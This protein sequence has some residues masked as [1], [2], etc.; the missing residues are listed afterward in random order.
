MEFF[1]SMSET[2]KYNDDDHKTLFLKTLNEQRLEGEFC[3]I[4]I[5]VE[6][7]KFRA[8]RC[9]LAACSTYFKKLFK[10]L[11]VDSSSVIEIDFLRSDIFEEVLNYMYTAK[12][13]VKKEDVNLM[14][15]SGQIL[16]IRFLDKLCSQ[17]RDVSS[18]D[19]S[20]GQSKSKYCLKLNRPI[21]D[22]ADAQDDD[23]EEI[24]DQ[25]DSP[26]DDTVEG[27]PPSQEDGKSPTTTL[28]VQEAILKELGSEEVRKV[29]C[30][31]QE[32]E[33]METPESKDL[34]SQTPQALTFNDGM[35]EVKDEQTP[36]W[37]T[38]AS[39]MKFE[40]LLYGHH[41]EQIACQACGK[42]FSDEGRL[43]KHEKLHTAD[44]PFVCEMCTK[45]FTT[46]A[47]LKEHLKIHTGYKPYSCEVCG[48]SFIRAPDLK[49][50]ERVHSNERPF[51]CHMCDKAFKHKSHLKDHERRHR[52]EKPF[53]CGSC[54][55]AFAKASDL[56]RHENNMHNERKQVTPSAIQ[57]ETEQL[58]AAAMAA[59][60]EQQLETIACS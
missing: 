58:Q 39:D 43:R 29:N 36:G 40:Y 10:K 20:N 16:G 55:K 41:R 14:M 42:T 18:P 23:V 21:G 25:D 3:D 19:E 47:H 48:K 24:G 49:K 46:Q 60:A 57:S 8:H 32:V 15:S 1:I 52:G 59:E 27:T 11:E 30:Y 35:G 37:T 28:R 9:V 5:V 44:R 6:D 13:S 54:T 50:H 22:A 17:K 45:G 4:A 7:V 38:A 53:V 33:S 51:A 26:S 31:G 12:I 34:G 2:I 56:K